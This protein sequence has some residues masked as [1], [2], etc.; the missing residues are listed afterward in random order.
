MNCSRAVSIL[1]DDLIP[2]IL[3]SD[4]HWWPRDFQRLALVSQAWVFPVRKRLYACPSLRS[5]RACRLLARTFTENLDLLSHVRRLELRPI[6]DGTTML[7]EQE[8]QSL[9]YIL[10]LKGL[11]SITLGGDLAVA[12][13]RFLSVMYDTRNVTELHIDGYLILGGRS[14]ILS[15]VIPS[16]E[17][18]DVM[19]FRFPNLR[20]LTLSNVLLAIIPP[21]MD[22]PSGLTH[23]TLNNVDI[24]L[25]VLPD[26]CHGSWA[27]LRQLEVIGGNAVEQDDG[28]RAMLD[29][30]ANIETFHYEAPDAFSHLP[31]FDEE[32]P[33][34]PSLRKLCISGLDATSRTLQA[35]AQCCPKLED[36]AVLGR[37]HRIPL[38]EWASYIASD[39]LP[40]LRRLIVPAGTNHPPFTFWSPAEHEGLLEVCDARGIALVD[41][42]SKSNP[43]CELSRFP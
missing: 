9:R 31:V 26:I 35:I 13:Q 28:I 41:L 15:P 10:T 33:S 1:V 16:L 12:A 27:T 29:V 14:P 37:V 18:D 40:F 25:G 21:M 22:R 36:L 38:E 3:E 11:R 7:N 20:T 30:C 42:T 4:D 2:S 23:L 17:W 6:S 32:P 24:D 19:A 43:S 8:M 39:A 5:Y 34:C